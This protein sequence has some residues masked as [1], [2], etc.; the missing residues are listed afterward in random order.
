MD[1][2]QPAEVSGVGHVAA[3]VAALLA[4]T[5]YTAQ[6]RLL[7]LLG[8]EYV[9]KSSADP[10]SAQVFD[11]PQIVSTNRHL[12]QGAV[13][14]EIV[15]WD[16]S[17]GTLTAR[18]RVVADDRYTVTLDVPA[19]YRPMDATVGDQSVEVE[20]HGRFARLSFVSPQSGPVVWNV[21]F[22]Q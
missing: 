1:A 7:I 22:V 16:E 6:S 12:S 21:R 14:L 2:A 15:G 9:F 18:S 13:D 20:N 8:G 19:G 10:G 17:T 4:H 11:R 3:F 5:V